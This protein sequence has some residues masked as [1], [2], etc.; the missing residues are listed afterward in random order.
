VVQ[1]LEEALNG[2]EKI[3]VATDDADFNGIDYFEVN[4]LEDIREYLSLKKR[5]V[6][7]THLIRISLSA[8]EEIMMIK[9]RYQRGTELEEAENVT[10]RI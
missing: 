6:G 4:D 2:D 7:S 1:T 9:R 10:N 8:F 5:S 3:I